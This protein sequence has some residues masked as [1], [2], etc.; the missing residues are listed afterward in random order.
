M[1]LSS[2]VWLL[3]RKVQLG[4][5][6]GT[7]DSTRRALV[8]TLSCKS[9]RILWQRNGFGSDA[10]ERRMNV[11]KI[12]V[13]EIGALD[14]GVAGVVHIPW[15]SQRKSRREGGRKPVGAQAS[16]SRDRLV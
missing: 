1:Q 2:S 4:V 8:P 7:G 16:P 12:V 3:Q 15:G 10:S 13:V 11:W 14:A 6:K 5:Q 9:R